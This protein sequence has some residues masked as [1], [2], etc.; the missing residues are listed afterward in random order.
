[1]FS[2]KQQPRQKY[3]ISVSSNRTAA[4]WCIESDYSRSAERTNELK[5]NGH[6][7]WCTQPQSCCVQR[8]TQQREPSCCCVIGLNATAEHDVSLSLFAGVHQCLD[9]TASHAGS[10]VDC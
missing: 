5:S 10:A 6:S 3:V 4:G 1:V 8:M 2:N 9:L 7:K